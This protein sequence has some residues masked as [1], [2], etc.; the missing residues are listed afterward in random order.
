MAHILKCIL[1]IALLIMTII[2]VTKQRESEHYENTTPQQARDYICRQQC[3]M[4]A[5]GPPFLGGVQRYGEC[6]NHCA[7]EWSDPATVLPA[8]WI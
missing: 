6:M 1:T 8:S 2:L 4:I 3:D 7:N 5:A